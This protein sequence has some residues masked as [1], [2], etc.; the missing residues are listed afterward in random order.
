MSVQQNGSRIPRRI[1]LIRLSAIGD[2]VMASGLVPALR[3]KYPDAHLA[4]LAEPAA[5]SLLRENP[6][7]DE[8]I[9]WPR[10][11]WAKHLRAG[12]WHTLFGM[13]R[14]MIAKLR[15]RKFDLVLDLQGLL[16]SG[17]MAFVTGAPER[18]SLGGRE[19]SRWLAH[20]VVSRD[21]PDRRIGSEYRKLAGELGLD[22]EDFRLSLPYSE[23]T[24]RQA[25][26]IL[27]NADLAAGSR[28][29]V[30][31]PLTTRPEKHWIPHLWQNLASLLQQDP[32]IELVILGAGSG[33]DQ[34]DAWFAGT[35]RPVHNLCGKTSLPEAVAVIDRADLVIGVDTGLTH[36]GIARRRPTIALFGPTRPYLLPDIPEA[37][38]SVLYRDLDCAPCGRHP[39][40]NG[41]FTCMQDLTP[42]EVWRVARGYLEF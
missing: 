28:M 12:H 35:P 15:S 4:W 39:T 9:V 5:A 2:A 40:C 13:V 29:V 8:V 22:P 18:V 42:G 27:D 31:C 30:C 33:A 21:T 10:R 34:T 41:A 26:A 7:L 1:L 19:G 32:T 20:R 16:K 11:E 36:M 23:E 24:G 6:D 3:K 38:L 25:A 14:A 17:S 37:P